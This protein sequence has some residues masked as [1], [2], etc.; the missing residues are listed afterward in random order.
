[1]SSSSEFGLPEGVADDDLIAAMPIE[2]EPVQL[3]AHFPVTLD[4]EWDEELGGPELEEV[5]SSQ[6]S[7]FDPSTNIPSDPLSELSL[8]E[9]D[10]VSGSQKADEEEMVKSEERVFSRTFAS[11]AQLR[12]ALQQTES[13]RGTS[14]SKAALSGKLLA[15]RIL[16]SLKVETD[17]WCRLSTL[18]STKAQGYVQLSWAS[19]NKFAV[20]QDV[21]LWA[22]GRTKGPGQQVSHLCHQPKCTIP[23]HVCVESVEDNN[24][25]KG[26]V[27]HMPCLDFCGRCHGTKSVWYCPH[28]PPCIL[29]HEDYASQ[30]DFLDNG[31]CHSRATDV[32]E[33]KRRRA[34]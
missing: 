31:I 8:T 20:L 28:T 30:E 9:A 6:D 3:G 33:Q 18:A 25:R 23:S 24:S 22:Q 19:Q 26:C 7:S 32:R 34:A 21:L 17:G 27:I 14:T 1:M 11:A 15:Q 16:R 10:T 29:A 13:T 12:T 5:G 4:C 2:S